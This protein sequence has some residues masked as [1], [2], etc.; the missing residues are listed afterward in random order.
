MQR[1][2][3]A[4]IDA[5]TRKWRVAAV[6]LALL[7]VALLAIA[8]VFV[9]TERGAGEGGASSNPSAANELEG[10]ARDT[11]L[12]SG[13]FSRGSQ[14]TAGSSRTDKLAG[15]TET[16]DENGVVHGVTPEGIRYTIIGRGTVGKS[17]EDKVTLCAVGDQINTDNNM[18][19][20]AAYGAAYGTGD[21]DYRPFYQEVKPIIQGY[22]LRYMNQETVMAGPEVGYSGYPV[23]NAP[24]A[25]FDS[26]VDVGFNMV[27]FCSNHVW[28]MGQGGIERTLGMFATH[29]EI[30]VDGSYRS[31]EDA[32]TVHMI[33]VNGITFASLGY[34]YWDNFYG[35][36]PNPVPY[37]EVMFDKELMRADVERAR[38]VA[39][40]VIVSMH[41]GTEYV[42]EPN[43]VQY[44]YAQYL[45]D[46]GVDLVLGTHA[47]IMQPTKYFTGAGGNVTP[48]VF[49]LSD[50]VSGWTLVDTILSGLFT[51][52][53]TRDPATG[54]VVIGNLLWTPTIEWSN[55]GEV[56]VRVIKNMSI[57]EVNSSTRID[58]VQ[59]VSYYDYIVNKVNS[60][61]MEI[62]IDL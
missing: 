61:G 3:V 17:G 57:D 8:L 53:F 10:E 41:W 47:H 42:N 1:K 34:S 28:D 49:G 35:A 31:A 55:G 40:V 32:E 54:E 4:E 30:L 51:C 22:D 46:L 45:A 29:P 26:I 7:L 20:A 6:V 9:F 18:P 33:E 50:F 24:D 14:E 59:G 39:D 11:G 13:F 19:I 25:C 48:V 5:S 52:D 43:D 58:D 27:N 62:P 21:Y 38:A 56:Y 37:Y 15:A 36:G 60:I 2:S 16:V 12:G 23:F 44:E